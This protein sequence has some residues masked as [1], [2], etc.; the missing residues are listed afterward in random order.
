MRG[1]YLGMLASETEKKLKWLKT[2]LRSVHGQL[3]CLPEELKE[4]F[5]EARDALRQLFEPKNPQGK[6]Q[7]ELQT[8]K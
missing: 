1:V 2:R 8:R 7:A 6:Y 3:S 5:D 4:D